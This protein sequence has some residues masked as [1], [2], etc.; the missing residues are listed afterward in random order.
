M[1]AEY[2]TTWW[3]KQWLLSLSKIDYANRIPRG[4]TY[5]N[6]GKVLDVVVSENRIT[7]KVKGHYASYYDVSVAVPQFTQKEKDILID[8]IIQNNNIIAALTNSTLAPEILDIAKEKDIQIFPKRWNDLKMYCDC[9]DYAVPCKHLAAVIYIMS[10]EIDTD[11]FVL[12]RIKGL[13]ILEEL[14]KRNVDITKTKESIISTWRECAQRPDK[15]LSIDSKSDAYYDVFSENNDEFSF[16]KDEQLFKELADLT[17]ANIPNIYDDLL[18]LLHETPPGY[19]RIVLRDRLNKI[20]EDASK[21]AKKIIYKA[22]VT[23]NE[24]REYKPS[25]LYANLG[26]S[27]KQYNIL[28]DYNFILALFSS[29]TA[30]KSV[31]SARKKELTKITKTLKNEPAIFYSKHGIILNN[32]I[33]DPFFSL[34]GSLSEV[35]IR[36]SSNIEEILYRIKILALRLI[37]ARTIVPEIINFNEGVYFEVKTSVKLKDS[38]SQIASC[39]VR[40]IPAIISPEIR[41]ICYKLGKILNGFSTKLVAFDDELKPSFLSIGISALSVFISH[42]IHEIFFINAKITDLEDKYTVALFNAKGDALPCRGIDTIFNSLSNWIA[43]YYAV[44]GDLIPEL[45]LN[46]SYENKK[47]KDPNDDEIFVSFKIRTQEEAPSEHISDILKKP[48]SPQYFE[49]LKLVGKL[50][51]YCPVL[52]EILNKKRKNIVVDL[53]ELKDIMLHSIPVLKLTGA[54]IIL[55]KNL[56][57]LLKPKMQLKISGG[58]KVSSVKSFLTLTSML[59]FDWQYAIGDTVISE[60]EFAAMLEYADKIVRFKDKY[61]LFTAED[62]KDI[63][64]QQ[65]LANK[66]IASNAL[67]VA[68][69]TEDFSGVETVLDPDLKAKIQELLAFKNI[70]VPKSINATLRPYQLNGFSWMVKNATIGLGSIIADDMGLGKTLQVITVIDYLRSIGELNN[71]KVLVVVPKTLLLN[72]QREILKFAP[73]LKTTVIYGTNETIDTDAHVII[74]T[75]GKV[76]TLKELFEKEKLRLIIIDEAQ[77]IKNSYTETR[78]AICSIKAESAIAM[79]GTPVENRL[80]EYWSIFDYANPGLL[81]SAEN[82]RKTYAVPIESD[83]NYQVLEKFKALTAPFIMRRMKTDKSIISDLPEKIVTEQYCSLTTEQVALYQSIVDNVMKKLE[84]KNDKEVDNNKRK[85]LILGMITA[86]KQI[87]N[88]PSCFV[89]KEDSEY[90][91]SG[92]GEMLMEL[93]EEQREVN[94]KTIIFTQFTETGVLLQKWIKDKFGVEPE[95]LHGA[96]TAKQRDEMVNRFQ[97]DRHNYVLI[98]SLKAAGTGLNITAASTVIHFDLWWNPAVENQATDRAYRIGQKNV[99]NVY[100]FVTEG[101]FEEKIN[102]MIHAKQELSD[103]TLAQGEKWIGDMSNKEIKDLFALSKE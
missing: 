63:L 75:Y 94:R 73:E 77:N 70:E 55:P 29:A 13:D 81:G 93:L 46:S 35:D 78:K 54:R 57:K 89:K 22:S 9:P 31:Q 36:E 102:K 97:K 62:L 20:L 18:M 2:G 27:S 71:K 58:S 32:E 50:S 38:N 83:R 103:I 14:S 88:A 65:K 21:K 84:P 1:A 37:E 82:F 96:N 66:K 76:R 60:A 61:V 69:L 85:G 7:A 3:G 43:P 52:K 26:I 49:C 67:L 44:N 17:F 72:W 59:A 99:V 95:F 80:Q 25:D 10:K 34:E 15:G 47:T 4:K 53:E 39:S 90:K 24:L 33:L 48:N 28:K 23:L 45:E 6:T 86:L 79:S 74:T 64:K 16:E 41:N 56:S 100:R 92:K 98:L 5:A 87:C 68:A 91:A 51:E 40:W 11:P 19:N 12:F 8:A 42:F 30:L 101:T